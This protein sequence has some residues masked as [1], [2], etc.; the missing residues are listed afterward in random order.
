MNYLAVKENW[1]SIDDKLPPC[2]L[3]VIAFDRGKRHK[4][5]YDRSTECWYQPKIYSNK[6][7]LCRM[8]GVTK[9]REIEDNTIKMQFQAR[10]D[11]MKYQLEQ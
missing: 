1:Y 9:W 8:T 2:G 10:R 11:S 7:K 3:Y 4:G 5:F 6:T